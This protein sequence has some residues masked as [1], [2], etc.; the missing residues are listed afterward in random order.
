MRTK[1]FIL[2]WASNLI[3][4]I[5]L[6]LENVLMLQKH[7]ILSIAYKTSFVTYAKSWIKHN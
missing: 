4:P 1:D 7:K 6:S 3:L 5:T 2:V